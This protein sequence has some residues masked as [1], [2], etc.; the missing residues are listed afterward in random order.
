MLQ[1]TEERWE[2]LRDLNFEVNSDVQYRSDPE[3]Y[4]KPDFWEIA[5]E[6]GDC[7]DYALA[8][9]KRLR[10]A[11]WPK[12]SALLAT[13]WVEGDDGPGTGGY[14]A[15][16]VIVSSE[17]DYVLDNRHNLPMAW[18]DLPYRWHK[19]EVPGRLMWAYIGTE[20]GDAE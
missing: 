15:V 7:E 5:E 8:K 6:E 2:E 13:C 18:P 17:G 9:R 10:D 4:D 14:H 16:L 20:T 19:R 1:L 3:L 11:G 12:D